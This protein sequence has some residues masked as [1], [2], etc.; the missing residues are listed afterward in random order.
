[1]TLSL[2]YDFKDETQTHIVSLTILR[3]YHLMWHYTEQDGP[4]SFH[5]SRT[6]TETEHTALWNELIPLFTQKKIPS[7]IWEEL[8]EQIRSD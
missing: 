7:W 1:M 4:C 6:L 5:Q 2:Y 8:D 3:D